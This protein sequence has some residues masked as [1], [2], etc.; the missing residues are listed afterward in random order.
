ML[1]CLDN[2]DDIGRYNWAAAIAELT[3]HKFEDLVI[4]VREKRSD[5]KTTAKRRIAG[6]E[7]GSAFI[8]GCSV[9]LALWYLEHTRLRQPI[10]REAIPRL[11]RW[12]SVLDKKLSFSVH[13][14]QGQQVIK[15]LKLVKIEKKAIIGV[16]QEMSHVQT[17][18]VAAPPHSALIGLL[19]GLGDKIRLL[20][21]RLHQSISSGEAQ[22][23]VL[24]T[25]LTMGFSRIEKLICSTS[26]AQDQAAFGTAA[27]KCSTPLSLTHAPP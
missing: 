3:L 11:F 7:H 17:K 23:K 27:E 19:Q 9:A 26:M 16:S 15:H 14:L 25:A 20:P 22:F 13:S 4:V 6:R 1:V 10:D 12:G 18:G 8:F 24:T 2:I 21:K 5:W